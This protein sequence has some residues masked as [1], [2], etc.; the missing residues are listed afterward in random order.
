MNAHDCNPSLNNNN[1]MRYNVI[2]NE[3]LVPKLE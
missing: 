1:E 3:P 2:E